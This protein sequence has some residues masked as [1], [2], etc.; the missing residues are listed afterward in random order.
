ME[1]RPMAE[2]VNPP[3]GTAH[4]NGAT[5]P[6]TNSPSGYTGPQ[7]YAAF[8]NSQFSMLSTS[9]PSSARRALEAHMRDTDRRI[10][11]AARLGMTL[12]SQRSELAAKL[13][14]VEQMQQDG[15]IPAELQGRLAELEREYNE[16]GRE[17]ARAFL[18]KSRVASESQDMQSS[19]VISGS[20]RE[21][22]TKLSAPSRRQRNQPTNRVHDIEFA[23]EISTSLLA[24]VRQ[25][26]SALAEKDDQLKDTTSAKALLEAE[27]AHLLQ[28]LRHMDESEQKYKDENWNLETRLQD[29]E[30]SLKESLDKESRLAQ[31]L[32]SAQSDKASKERELDELRLSHEKLSEDQANARKITDNDFYSLQRDHK[33]QLT[34]NEKLQAKVRE[35]TSQNTELAKAVA[36]RMGQQVPQSDTDFMSAEENM[37]SDEVSPDHSAPASPIKGTPARHGMLESETLKSSLNHAH[38]MIQNLKN[39]IHREKTEKIELK[40]MLQDARDELEQR[41]EN[42]GITANVAK[43]RKSD[44]DVKF[45][46]PS[47]NRLGAAR[48]STTEIID[49]PDWE[50]DTIEQTPSRAR[51]GVMSRATV[52]GLAA[53]TAYDR[54]YGRS[55]GDTTDAFETANETDTGFETATERD[56]TTESEAFA[57]GAEDL[58]NDTEGDATETEASST[59]KL[60][61]VISHKRMSY[62]STAST[63]GDEDDNVVGT[64]VRNTQQPKYK[65]RLSRGG[66]RSGRVSDVMQDS[67]QASQASPS[68]SMGTPQAP[69]MQSLGDELDAL[70]DDDSIEGTP[71]FERQMDDS[72]STET[73]TTQRQLSVGPGTPSTAT[74]SM[75]DDEIAGVLPVHYTP[76]MSPR[77]HSPALGQSAAISEPAMVDAGVMTEPWQPEP[78]VQQPSLLQHAGEV[79]AGALAG[80]GISRVTGQSRETTPQDAEHDQTAPVAGE[81]SRM[82]DSGAQPTSEV[83]AAIQPE[84]KMITIG[85]NARG[86]PITIST[87]TDARLI[88]TSSVG[89]DARVSAI[90]HVGTDARIASTSHIGTDARAPPQ[91]ISIGTDARGNP[92]TISIGTAT[93]VE[94]VPEPLMVEELPLAPAS[95]DHSP[96]NTQQTEPEMWPLSPNQRSMPVVS[97]TKSVPEDIERPPMPFSA[98]PPP[99]VQ[100]AFSDVLSQEFEPVLPA[101]VLPISPPHVTSSDKHILPISDASPSISRSPLAEMSANAPPTRRAPSPPMF[102]EGS[103]TVVS[104]DEIDSMFKNKHAVS[105]APAIR[106]ADHSPLK[107]AAAA[108]TVALAASTPTKQDGRSTDA[109]PSI[110]ES[111][112]LHPPGR[113]PSSSSS[114]RKK[115]AAFGAPPLPADHNSKIAAAQVTPGTPELPP[116]RGTMGPPVMP[117]SA[118][119]RPNTPGGRPYYERTLHSRDSTTP[120]PVRTKDSRGTV[121]HVQSDRVSHR[122][123]VSS[124]ASELD[125]R[126]NISR[127][128][129]ML[130]PDV[131]PATDPRMIQAITQT[132]IGEYLWKYTRKAG[133]SETSTTRHR[134]F[135]W[136]HPYTRTL[137]WSEHDPSTAGKHMMK[138]KSVAI[139]AVRVI[140]DDN[141]YPPGLHR[142]SLVVITPGREIVFTAPTGQRHE[143][144]FNALSYLLLRT[145]RGHKEAEDT[146]S[147]AELEDFNP[148]G[149]SGTVRR[150]ISRMAGGTT[151][152]RSTSRQ[153]RRTSLSSYNS[154]T[155]RTT[156]PQ[157]N[158]ATLNG[159]TSAASQYPKVPPMPAGST[160]RAT[161]SNP[162]RLSSGSTQGRFSSMASR[163]RPGSSHRAH[164]AASNRKADPSDPAGIYDAS[165]VGDS[166]EDLRAVIEQQERDADRLENV[167]ACCDGK[168]DVGSLKNRGG[169]GKG[170]FGGHSHHS[171][172]HAHGTASS[173]T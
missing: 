27:S 7:R 129:M 124:F 141:A 59:R 9:S 117:A 147:D 50:D 49:E 172:T 79:A 167:R 11:D 83:E 114:M 29:V 110:Y 60:R 143:T 90:S 46:R 28:R 64:P 84:R 23:T 134:R 121:N 5:D 74:T 139:E 82:V 126:F 55:D 66:R 80:F 150:S 71:V 4:A 10:K 108:A 153:S 135:F 3:S 75:D 58:G 81:E 132:M 140:T 96:I 61:P 8:D 73:P 133:R 33:G 115:D 116:S 168:H 53:A 2:I 20:G 36:F 35:L 40:R 164:S 162:S 142:K 15:E 14:E 32:K 169:T 144:W 130:P 109:R 13:K 68:S 87:G 95:L 151:N 24:Q 122:T 77:G 57:T 137:Y 158:D 38:R 69:G 170:R 155:T 128:Q 45:K 101:P 89:T 63:S 154:R 91:R 173:R 25:L 78:A 21:S 86:V 12:T 106:D 161:D 88:P 70:D 160:L 92:V 138:A 85:T 31:T 43:K 166:A 34:E 6:F 26:Q 67:P 16:L 42:T 127:G 97:A 119:K 103:Q 44:N 22:P 94:A 136:V 41:R 163:F 156:S 105:S 165:V 131:E 152:G 56:G 118:Y 120:R 51:D 54:V 148:R 65:L 157:R 52:A 123:S 107:N 72:F 99:P 76:R 102:D 145:E 1:R 100:L 111:P 149:I 125:E 62:M 98:P 47:H 112:T 37:Q 104:G 19:A 159:R 18:P 17:S 30:A 146:M 113:R 93:D 48:S 39:N 171:H